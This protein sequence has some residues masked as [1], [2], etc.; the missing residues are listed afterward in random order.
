MLSVLRSKVAAVAA[1][2]M[3]IVGLGSYGAVAGGLIGSADIR[4][5][6]V[7][8][9]DVGRNAVGRQEIIDDSVNERQLSRR[10]VRKVN[11]S[12]VPGADGEKG[13]TGPAGED[14]APGEDG[15]PG[16]D[17]GT[18][19]LYKFTVTHAPVDPTN[20][21]EVVLGPIFVGPA[22]FHAVDYQV[23]GNLLSCDEASVNV[24]LWIY[25]GGVENLID[26]SWKRVSG[27][28]DPSR[29]KP[30]YVRVV[31]GGDAEVHVTADC[32]E[33]GEQ[34]VVPNFEVTGVFAVESYDTTTATVIE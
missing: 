8:K 3:I 27:A 6:G 20:N 5:G 26:W 7:R 34:V 16:A 31:G 32:W 22:T 10:V 30:T 18:A 13:D 1:G 11:S 9:A 24:E 33:S 15:V 21:V 17:G 4:D 23:T 14:G 2:S 28:V 29:G 25:H 12:S 19:P